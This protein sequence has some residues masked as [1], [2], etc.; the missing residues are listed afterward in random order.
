[1]RAA[2]SFHLEMQLGDILTDNS[3]PELVD[4]LVSNEKVIA[5][6]LRN[7]GFIN[8]LARDKALVAELVRRTP[9][10]NPNKVRECRPRL[11][12]TCSAPPPHMSQL[13]HSPAM[14]APA[15]PV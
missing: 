2:K 13:P 11:S 7:D 14:R 4:A 12:H 10:A 15:T 1:M 3:V 6:L 9:I 5:V 8:R